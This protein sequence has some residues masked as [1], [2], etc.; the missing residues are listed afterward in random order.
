MSALRFAMASFVGMI[1]LTFLYNAAGDLVLGSRWVAWLGG[2][3]LVALFFV[4]PWWIER[5]DPFSMSRHF[6]HLAGA[7]DGTQQPRE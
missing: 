3:L 1:P 5:F 6:R 4:L 7:P 2:A